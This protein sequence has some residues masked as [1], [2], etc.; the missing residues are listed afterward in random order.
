MWC[1]CTVYTLTE[2]VQEFLGS[3]LSRFQ[4]EEILVL[5]NELGVH[6]GVQ[7]L[8]VGENIL[9]EWDVGLETARKTRTLNINLQNYFALPP[10]ERPN[11]FDKYVFAEI[12]IKAY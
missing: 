9:E 11:L 10:D 7:K 4:V 1:L 8:I 12:D 3:V 2:V 6:G 5:V